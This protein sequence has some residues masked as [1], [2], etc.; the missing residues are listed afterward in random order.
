VGLFMTSAEVL[1]KLKM[2]LF[3][4][5]SHTHF[6]MYSSPLGVVV[7]DFLVLRPRAPTS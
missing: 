3:S 2:R 6:L 1:R 4:D 5:S 7:P